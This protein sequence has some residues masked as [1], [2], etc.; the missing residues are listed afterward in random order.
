MCRWIVVCVLFIFI[1]FI[2]FSEDQ[3]ADEKKVIMDMIDTMDTYNTSM[4]EAQ[5]TIQVAD[6]NSVL[7]DSLEIHVPRMKA[8]SEE[9]PEWGETPPAEI[10]P[11]LDS[12]M[13]MFMV[14][15]RESLKKAVDYANRYTEDQE[16]QDSFSRLNM[17]IMRMY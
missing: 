6:A 3:Y 10:Q 13:E 14:F 7:S 8:L 11:L 1:P 16:L 9:Y 4:S 5:S 17:I 2:A 12:Y 15:N